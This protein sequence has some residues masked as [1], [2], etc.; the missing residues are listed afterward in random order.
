MKNLLS[1]IRCRLL[2]LS[3][4]TLATLYGCSNGNELDR[5]IAHDLLVSYGEYPKNTIGKLVVQSRHVRKIDSKYWKETM[6][7]LAELENRALAKITIIPVEPKGQLAKLH[8]S[9]FFKVELTE[10]GASYVR[11]KSSGAGWAVYKD[12]VTYVAEIGEVTGISFLTS[13]KTTARVEYNVKNIPTP[14]GEIGRVSFL[15]MYKK[16]EI[17]EKTALLR[18]FDDGWRVVK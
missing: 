1:T 9:Q 6:E 14:F 13:E 4:M 16:D 11:G 2:V 15:S 7:A 8:P 17:E 18:L 3:F 12:V 5:G 10:K